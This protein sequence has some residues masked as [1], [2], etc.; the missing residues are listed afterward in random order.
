MAQDTACLAALRM[1]MNWSRIAKRIR[2]PLGFLFA[3]L[4]LFLARPQWWS[5]GAGSAVALAGV[6]IRALASGHVKKNQELAT[7]GPYAYTRNPLYLGSLVIA[8]GFLLAAL[9]WELLL[10]AVLLFTAIYLPVIRAEERFLA[11]HFA[12][13]ADY[14]TRV[15]RLLPRLRAGAEGRTCF[16]RELYWHNREYNALL[17]TLAIIAVLALRLWW[18]T[19]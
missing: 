5:L 13:Y 4:Y 14:R 3:A 15:P 8:A 18:M 19:R 10:V 17:G 9:R 2:V 7:S 16:S 12:G 6:W 1:K 11:E